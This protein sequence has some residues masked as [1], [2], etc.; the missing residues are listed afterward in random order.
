MGMG[1]YSILCVLFRFVEL[2]VIW[3][4]LGLVIAY[5]YLWALLE[6]FVTYVV[7][8][9]KWC[10][11]LRW[12]MVYVILIYMWPSYAYGWIFLEVHI[13]IL[14]MCLCY[15]ELWMRVHMLHSCYLCLICTCL[16]GAFSIHCKM[17]MCFMFD[18]IYLWCLSSITKKGKIEASRPSLLILVIND[19]HYLWTNRCLWAIYFKLGPRHM[20]AWMIIDGLKLTAQSKGKEDGKTSALIFE[21]IEV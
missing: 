18:Y 2:Y 11:L 5:V 3:T 9:V 12:W 15:V 13:K 19:K 10:E 6:W 17:S 20:C 1:Y 4:L 21:L 16:G 14:H 7:W 8:M